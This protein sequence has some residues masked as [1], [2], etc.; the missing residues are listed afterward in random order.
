MPTKVGTVANIHASTAAYCVFMSVALLSLGDAAVSLTALPSSCQ[1]PVLRGVALSAHNIAAFQFRNISACARSCCTLDACQAWTFVEKTDFSDAGDPMCYLKD[2]AQ[3]EP[4]PPGQSC[5]SWSRVPPTP[6]PVPARCAR[7]PGAAP[8]DR[9]WRRPERNRSGC[10]CTELALVAETGAVAYPANANLS[11]STWQDRPYPW[12]GDAVV[13]NGT[14]HGF[15]AEFANHCPMTYG[16]WYTS[17][18]IRHAVAVAD[19]AGRPSSAFVPREIAIPRAAGNPVLIKHRTVDGYWLMYFTNQRF[20]RPVRSCSGRDPSLWHKEAVYQAGSPM[21]VNLAFSHS[22]DGPWSIRY[23]LIQ[24]F[25]T[26][27]AAVLLPN[28]TVLLAYKTWPSP[29]EC[30][31]LIGKQPCKA[32]GLYST[33]AGGW[34]GSYTHRPIGDKYVAVA[35]DIEDPSLY[36]DP[37]SGTL[38]MLVHTEDGGGSGGSAHS[39]DLGKTWRFYREQHAYEYG[40]EMEGGL[41]L[42]LTNREEPKLLLDAHGYPLSLINQA[43]VRAL[44]GHDSPPP[45][46]VGYHGPQGTHLTFTLMQQVSQESV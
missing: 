45:P 9:G 11:A 16:T 18:H 28:G 42:H 30:Q 24:S 37:T 43:A 31:A 1:V 38:H 26:N 12:G 25:S 23:E 19:S 36:R 5:T 46:G 29:A 44:R 2:A 7:A 3:R 8:C 32:I 10:D 21:G 14:V 17:T 13:Q 22:L 15:F 40:V 27:P 33:G 34:N 20:D 35:T 4:C 39:T 41:A 6:V